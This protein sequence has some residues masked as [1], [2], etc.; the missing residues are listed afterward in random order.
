MRLL[1]TIAIMAISEILLWFIFSVVAKFYYKKTEI[2][3]ES[4]FK[5]CL[6]RLFLALFLYNDLP[7]ALT[8]FS[9]L[10]IA[11]RLK[12]EERQGETQRFNNYYLIGN[13]I[14]V[15]MSLFYLYL[16]NHASDI[17]VALERLFSR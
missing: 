6:E 8:V 17:D 10:K 2:D 16:W 3:L 4:L 9:A 12:H 11:T 14:S 1:I 15:S 7:H 5:G 13:L